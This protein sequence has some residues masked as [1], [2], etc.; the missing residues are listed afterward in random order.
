[1]I[2]S[3]AACVPGKPLTNDE[4]S[5]TYL[6]RRKDIRPCYQSRHPRGQREM[7]KMS[8][9]IGEKK[10]SGKDESEVKPRGKAI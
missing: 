7:D 4:Q 3:L 10:E 9:G 8:D 2:S 6:P 5:D 1:M